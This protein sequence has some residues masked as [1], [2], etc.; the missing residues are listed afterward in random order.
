MVDWSAIHTI[1]VSMHEG[2]LT[3]AFIAVVV[4]FLVSILPKLPVIGWFF[5]DE[6]IAKV[7][8]YSEVTAFIAALGGSFGIVAAS[9]TGTILYT[10]GAILKSPLVM[11]K[12]MLTI[13]S[14]VFW[15]DFLVIRF[16][17]G[18]EGIWKNSVLKVF[19]TACALLGFAFTTVAGSLGGTL[20]GKESI[21][22]PLYQS[23]GVKTT[24]LWLLEPIV[25]FSKI[26]VNSPLQHLYSA[27]F[28]LQTVIILN[29]IILVLL[30]LYILA[31]SRSRK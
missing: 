16:K 2:M 14:F 4:R 11:N 27:S 15:V 30:L 26:L 17:F 25:Y 21:L 19:Y 24:E 3:L 12:V 23:L 20:A 29:A 28:I 8:R 6:F 1:T 22:E 10:P 31:S 13:F 5:S 18:E 9:I 7:S